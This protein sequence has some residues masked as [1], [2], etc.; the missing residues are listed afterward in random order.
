MPEKITDT[1][2]FI[3]ANDPSLD[4]FESQYRVPHGVSYNSYIIDAPK[5]TVMDTIDKRKS[6]EWLQNAEAVINGRP[7]DYLVIQHLEPDH[8][9]T[10]DLFLDKHPE[11][12]IVCS[13]KAKDMLPNFISHPVGDNVIAVKEGDTLD[14]GDRTLS[15]VAAPMVHWPEVIM[16]YD[17]KDKVLFSADGFGKFGTRN[18]DEIWDDEARRYYFNI[19]GKYGMQVQN[20]LKKAAGLDIEI[21]APLHGPTLSGDLS[22]Y[23]HLYDTWSKYQPESEGIFIAVASIHGHT[24]VVADRLAQ[25]LREKGQKVVLMDLTREDI[26]EA[27]SNCF[28]YPK[29]VFVACSYDAG[30]FPPME[31]LLHIL[32]HK[33]FRNRTVALVENGSWAPSAAKT[34]KNILEGCKDLTFVEPVVTIRTTMKDTDIPK[35]EE[36]A[37]HLIEAK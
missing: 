21:I 9:A 22:H 5:L 33:F 23:L 28:R 24:N 8:S 16:T 29:S 3:G 19:V 25:I 26:H 37:D 13:A 6:D 17:N 1:I 31:R 34:M 15:F 4:L 7:V 12:Q 20:V 30:V 14:L 11:T 10:I 2:S 36:L 18:A 32:T 27:V 35:L